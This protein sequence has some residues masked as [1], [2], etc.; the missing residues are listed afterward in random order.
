M[1]AA[2]ISI[3]AFRQAHEHVK[4]HAHH[5]PLLSSRSL[6]EASGFRAYL[7]AESF[8]RTGSYKIRGPVNKLAH[9]NEDEKRAGVICSSAGNH[10]QGVALA[11]AL[12]EVRAVVVMA[13]NATPSKIEATRAYGAEVVLHG[14]IWDEANEKALELVEEQGL[15]YIH[16]FD[17][18]DLITGQGT[19]GLEIYDDLPSVDTVVI[20]IGGGGL[21]SGV[22]TALKALNP[23]IR[24]VGVESSGA[25][26]MKRSVE[27][28]HRV[29]LDDVDCVID[30]LTVKRVGER[31]L[32]IVR[33]NVDEIVT[34]PDGK[35]FEALLWTLGRTKI[36]VEGA[37][38]APV[39]AVLNGLVDSAPGST[40][41]CVLSGGNIKL[42]QLSGMSWN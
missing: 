17:D 41:V 2:D 38:A 16:P 37:A 26:A 42:D 1:I 27:E 33:R 21:I 10:A 12:H 6:S 22:S 29:E 7:K 31:T 39:A 35:I 3:D 18:L 25:P 28:G 24:V 23:K 40:V 20:P 36:V 34:L 13:E 5:T 30:G 15:T 4:E 8:Q 9:L 14:S 32:E 19:L 11:A